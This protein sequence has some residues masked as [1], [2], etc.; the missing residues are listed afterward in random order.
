[1][2]TRREN[3]TFE[4]YSTAFIARGVELVNA[5]WSWRRAAAE[6]GI[7]SE[8]LRKRARSDGLN[9]RRGRPSFAKDIRLNL[10]TNP[11]DLAYLAG[12]LDGE[13]NITIA[14]Q[15]RNAVRIGIANTDLPLML[16]LLSIG[17]GMSRKQG[18]KGQ[19]SQT[20]C[21]YWQLYSRLDTRAFLQAVVP[22][23]RI[24]RN[25]ATLA[26]NLISSWVR[27]QEDNRAVLTALVVE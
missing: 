11:I 8:A 27:E 5:G 1:M 26:I 20:P 2:R 12:I 9:F 24:K 23:M 21:Y 10:P 6:L 25:K 4:P 15:P 18:R 22:Y 13:G 14:G 17:G 7:S 19:K 3:G 16:W